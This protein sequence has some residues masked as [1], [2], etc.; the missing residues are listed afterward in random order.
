MAKH[1]PLVQTASTDPSVPPDDTGIIHVLVVD[2]ESVIRT[3]VRTALED[4]GYVVHE[5][6]DGV[7][8]MEVLQFSPYPLIVVLD[9]MMP[10]MSGTEVLEFL[11]AEPDWAQR[12]PVVVLTAMGQWLSSKR[13]RALREKLEIPLVTKPFDVEGLLAAVD[14]AARRLPP[15]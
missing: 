7:I 12:Q 3:A 11:A 2:D 4:A 9:L 15:A 13:L 5:A 1:D 14:E 8:A 10:R 6:S